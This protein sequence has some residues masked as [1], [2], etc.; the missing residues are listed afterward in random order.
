M[1]ARGVPALQEGIFPWRAGHRRS[2]AILAA[3]GTHRSCASGRREPGKSF[4]EH[5]PG[6]TGAPAMVVASAAWREE[7]AIVSYR[8]MPEPILLHHILS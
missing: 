3:T 7:T 2:I 1:G 6:L 5:R 4:G 8:Y